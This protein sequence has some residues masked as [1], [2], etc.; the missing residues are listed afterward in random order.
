MISQYDF[1][2]KKSPAPLFLST[3]AVLFPPPAK[4]FPA[5]TRIFA[6]LP[7][8]AAQCPDAKEKRTA[9]KKSGAPAF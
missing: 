9:L 2:A 4:S 5:G 7:P 3:C 6:P 8:A 1:T